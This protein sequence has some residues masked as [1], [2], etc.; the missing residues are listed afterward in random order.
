MKEQEYLGVPICSRRIKVAQCENLNE[1][2][3]AKSRVWSSRHISFAGRSQLINTVLLSLH[4]YWAQ[5]FVLPTAML[6]GIEKGECTTMDWTRNIW[7][8]Y[9]IPKNS[10]CSWIVMQNRLP[11]TYRLLTMG[12]NIDGR[13][14]LCTRTKESMQHHKERLTL[15]KEWLQS[16]NKA[17]TLEIL[18]KWVNRR[19][20]HSKVKQGVWNAVIT[21]LIYTI[22]QV[23][24]QIKH[25]KQVMDCVKQMMYIKFQIKERLKLMQSKKMS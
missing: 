8:R 13:C 22:W 21:A 12:Q 5:V 10:F 16:N 18:F 14:F 1:R 23:R 25:G 11:T 19:S 17:C 20:R 15:V 24:N 3:T 7:N 4:Q 6:K 9:N 2:M